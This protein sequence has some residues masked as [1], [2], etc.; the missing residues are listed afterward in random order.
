MK[1]WIVATVIAVAWLGSLYLTY[2][3]GGLAG[4]YAPDA[5][6][7]AARAAYGVMSLWPGES[8]PPCAVNDVMSCGFAD[9]TGRI[10]VECG[11]FA[12]DSPER[13]VLLAF[14]QSNSANAARDRYVPLNE[15]VNFNPHDGKCYRAEDPLLGPD[16]NGGTVWGRLA[17]H[18]IQ[19]GLYRQ[20]MIVPIGIG[21]TELARWV[22]GGDLHARVEKTAAR[23]AHA[24]IR[25]TYV[26]WH[27]GEA[28][29]YAGTATD[30]YVAQFGALAASLTEQGIDAPVF[31]AVATRCYFEEAQRIEYADS[32]E[33]VRL[34]QASL[35]ERIPNVRPGPDTDTIS[36][37]EFRHD[38]CHFT[39]KGI[40]AHAMLWARAL[41]DAP[42]DKAPAS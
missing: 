31:P 29:V 23:L 30:E 11:V 2:G 14:G 37:A 24:G 27:Q 17:D 39:H 5:V 35:A 8:E 34:A 36:G 38:G 26:L 9:T 16:G 42:P 13:A 1:K 3:L 6:S 15:V 19:D 20:V 41:R 7:S 4:M 18:L 40:D 21:G 33:R 12:E 25:P 32:A 28:D 10:E 22:P